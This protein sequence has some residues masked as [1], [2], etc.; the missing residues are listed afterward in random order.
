M[1][2]STSASTVPADAS[3]KDR[4]AHNLQELVEEA[5][6]LLKNAASSGDQQLEV[7]RAKL[8]TQLRRLRHQVDE[9]QLGIAR[10]ARQAVQNTD[11]AAHSHPYAAMGLAALAGALLGVFVAHRWSASRGSRPERQ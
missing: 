10:Q 8:E 7:A 6:H 5:N 4:L 1:D 3:T 2:T 11:R 9:L